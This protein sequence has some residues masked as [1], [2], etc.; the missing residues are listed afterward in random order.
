MFKN[1]KTKMRHF[2]IEEA[3]ETISNIEK[4]KKAFP[5]DIASISKSND[6]SYSTVPKLNISELYERYSKF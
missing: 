4:S 5:E 1:P 3:D 6:V 2:K